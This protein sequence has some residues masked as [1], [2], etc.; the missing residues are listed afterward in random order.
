M[1]SVSVLLLAASLATPAFGQPVGV[2]ETM[3]TRANGGPIDVRIWYPAAS[4]G[5]ATPIKGPAVFQ[6][7]TAIKDAEPKEGR[8]WTILLSHGGLRSANGSGA[9]IAHALA[10]RGFLVAEIEPDG[11]GR[12]DDVWDRAAAINHALA[13]LESRPE[14][15]QR[16]EW[17]NVG[18]LGFFLG[19]T[20]AIGL[21]GGRIDPQV[22][23]ESCTR[24]LGADCDYWQ[25]KGIAPDAVDAEQL[26]RSYRN[27]QVRPVLAVAPEYAFAFDAQS[28]DEMRVPGAYLNLGDDPVFSGDVL[29]DYRF[30][31]IT[32]EAANPF[33]ALPLCTA[34]GAAILAEEGEDP[35][36]CTDQERRAEVH[37]AL[38]A[39]IEDYFRTEMP[40][41]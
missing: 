24:K 35:A 28:L 11:T 27:P 16:V 34:K 2:S 1:R 15:Q 33:D 39:A 12:P 41:D 6:A 36:L 4:E 17:H 26:A 14:W 23:A 20:A 40:R 19:G 22:F 10:E 38:I 30:Q 8:F 13:M 18:A 37:Q 3:V 25:A 5:S 7:E 31:K 32:I 21:G 29:K 9:W